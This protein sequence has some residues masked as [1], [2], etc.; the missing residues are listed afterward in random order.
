VGQSSGK[1]RAPDFKA[2]SHPQQLSTSAPGWG[3][4]PTFAFIMIKYSF[5]SYYCITLNLKAQKLNL[6]D[7]LIEYI[8]LEVV[9]TSESLPPFLCCLENEDPS[10][11]ET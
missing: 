11:D 9:V 7:G 2:M 5:I 10:D 1:I 6:K 3:A 8:F 4:V